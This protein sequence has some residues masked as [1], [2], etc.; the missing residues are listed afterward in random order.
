MP[1]RPRVI[2]KRGPVRTGLGFTSAAVRIPSHPGAESRGMAK[3][4][5]TAAMH[6]T[7]AAHDGD[8]DMWVVGPPSWLSTNFP[9]ILPVCHHVYPSVE[10]WWNLST[11][12][13]HGDIKG[14]FCIGEPYIGDL[15]GSTA[16]NTLA[17][18]VDVSAESLSQ[19]FLTDIHRAQRA[20]QWSQSWTRES[21]PFF[22]ER[23]P[24]ELFSSPAWSSAWE[25]RKRFGLLGKI[26]GMH[27]TAETKT[28]PGRRVRPA[29]GFC[30]IVRSKPSADAVVA[31]A[32]ARG[33]LD[34]KPRD[35][36]VGTSVAGWVDEWLRDT[37]GAGLGEQGQV[38]VA[39]PWVGPSLQLERSLREFHPADD[40]AWIQHWDLYWGWNPSLSSAMFMARGEPRRVLIIIDQFARP[41]VAACWPGN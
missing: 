29:I 6:L 10:S 34:W 2:W 7:M 41:F 36:N 38:V 15:V 19:N 27:G 31:M 12:L 3:A 28:V 39:C 25:G 40:P 26:L 8:G 35:L 24:G 14:L 23:R 9:S 22:L 18:A 13:A 32:C 5:R 17:H 16:M 33:D 30:G 37:T 11:A 21:Q 1:A 20:R 4:L